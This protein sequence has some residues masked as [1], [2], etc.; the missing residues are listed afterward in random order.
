MPASS[1]QVAGKT[2]YGFDRNDY[3]GDDLLPSLHRDFSFTGYWLSNP[4][5]SNHNSWLGKRAVLQAN[6]FGFMLLYNGRL[7]KELSGK[8]SADLG[9]ADG[10]AAVAA[11]RKE[12]FPAAATL[13]LDQEEGGRLL[14]EPSAYLFS[15]IAA[16]RASSYRPGVYCSGI[17]VAEGSSTITTAAQILS[18][19]GKRPIALWVVNDSYPPAPG[20]VIPGKIFPPSASGIPQALVW[21]YARSPRTDFARKGATGYAADKQCY[22]P[23]LTHNPETFVDLNVSASPDPSRGK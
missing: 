23:G 7:A 13:F 9:R 21:Q 11:A 6:G 19:E 20:C 22:A 4:P 15:W 17:P 18:H 5:R 8:D 1:G 2:F 3:P 14:A 10:A 16:V 12:G